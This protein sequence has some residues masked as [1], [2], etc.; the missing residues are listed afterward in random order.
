M[1]LF[2]IVASVLFLTGCMGSLSKDNALLTLPVPNAKTDCQIRN[3][4]ASVDAGVL[5]NR[6]TLNTQITTVIGAK[7]CKGLPISVPSWQTGTLQ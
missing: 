7:N 4:V 5:T 3:T 6:G 2:T 1:K